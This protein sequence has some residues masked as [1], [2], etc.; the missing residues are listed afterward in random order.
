MVIN[1]NN[2]F[3]WLLYL[4][5]FA[6]LVPSAIAGV[7]FVYNVHRGERARTQ[8]AVY[9]AFTITAVPVFVFMM[10]RDIYKFIRRLIVNE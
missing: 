10:L 1:M 2:V 7:Y 9:I 8:L 3:L 5:V 6:W 4:G